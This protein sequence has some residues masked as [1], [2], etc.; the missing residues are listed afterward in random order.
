MESWRRVYVGFAAVATMLVAGAVVY[1]VR[2]PLRVLPSDLSWMERHIPVHTRV[3]WPAGEPVSL[4]VNGKPE[5]YTRERQYIEVSDESGRLL[6][7]RYVPVKMI[8]GSHEIYRRWAP[9][10]MITLSPVSG[11]VPLT[12]T[13]T[14]DEVV[15]Q[16]EVVNIKFRVGD[17]TAYPPLSSVDPALRAEISNQIQVSWS[18]DGTP[19]LRILV[20]DAAATHRVGFGVRISVLV[21]DQVIASA[22]C[23]QHGYDSGNLWLNPVELSGNGDRLRDA[24]YVSEPTLVVRLDGDRAQALS[25]YESTSYWDGRLDIPGVDVQRG[26]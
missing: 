26:R 19:G 17:N 1:V 21:R 18:L 23:Y 24:V 7:R 20:P 10:E 3:V 4:V 8:L 16:Q 22:S 13:V 11:P 12:F 15:T 2:S 6:L 25:D 9:R 5:W 14:W